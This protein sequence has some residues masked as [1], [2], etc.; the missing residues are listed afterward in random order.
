M[1]RPRDESYKRKKR[2][3]Q[4]LLWVGT[5]IVVIV[6]GVAVSQI[7]PAAP[8][9]SRNEVWIEPVKRGDM[10]RQVRGPGTLVPEEILFV[11]TSTEGRVERVVLQP[12]VEVFADT[13]ILELSNPELEQSLQDAR[14]ALAAAEA[15]Y[16]NRVV[17]LQS[18]L[19]TQEAEL[20]RVQADLEAARLQAEADQ[21][22]FDDN[23]IA[24]IALKKSK[25]QHEQL[26]KRY[27]IE[28]QR[29][30]KTQES[31]EAQLE[32]SRAELEQARALYGLRRKQVALLSVQ[33]GIDG[34]LQEVPVEP[35]Q[36]VRPG[37][38][39]ARVANPNT[40]EAELRIPETQAKDL[41]VGQ[42]A[43]ID[44]RNGVVEGRLK[45][46]DP[47]VR[48]GTVLVDV[49]ITGELPRGARPDLSVDGTIEIERLENV[50]FVGRPAYGQPE[51]T[52]QFFRLTEDGQ[53]AHRVPV[54]LGK[55]SVNTIEIIQGLEEGDEI[56]LS[57]ISRWD[58]ENRLRIR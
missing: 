8:E 33:A 27:E 28:Q 26:Q 56:I 20:A 9:V 2:L 11:T 49:E 48:E 4:I 3:R 17:E 55:S 52:I 22:L 18:L 24:E 19:L 35:G 38:T 6:L 23:L 5:A 10:L 41:V 36:R 45:R 51:S 44:T 43:E 50:L 42:K 37:D 32:T 12:G 40:L 16:R 47:A 34:V 30:E 46:I 21:T 31:I 29:Y 1:D 15:R 7:E 58:D 25:I 14:L 53:M 13:V 54:Q 39:L 57:D